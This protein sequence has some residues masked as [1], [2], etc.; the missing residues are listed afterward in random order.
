ML[1]R[2]AERGGCW[3]AA[4]A[5]AAILL[6]SIATG[7][8]PGLILERTISL[9][10]VHGRI[11]H[12]AIDVE[13]KRL[14]VAELGN[15]TVAAIDLEKEQVVRQ[16]DGLHEPQ[17][18]SYAP[19]T[20]LL[21]VASEGDGSVRRL[22]ADDLASAG[23]TDLK[24]DAD[25]I[26]A[27]GADRVVVGYG[28]G[29]L[30]VIEAATGRVMADI[31]MPAHPEGF[32]IDAA[33]ERLYVNL[34]ENHSIEAI[35]LRSGKQ[36]GRW[37]LWLAAGNFP[38]ALDAE[39]G[40]LFSAYRWPAVVVSIDTR[41]GDVLSRV[42]TCS[43]ADDL[44]YDAQRKRLYVSCGSGDIAILDAESRLLERARVPTRT[45]ART[46]LFVPALDRLFLAVPQSQGRAAEIRVYA[47]R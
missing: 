21:Y 1:R 25:N 37:G 34:P 4:L 43:D 46:S 6:S 18:L 2:R 30:A 26:R 11:D 41:T 19:A 8:E 7:A 36:V 29:G 17:G 28:D 23:V 20:G 14:F 39:G 42:S 5:G 33:G 3:L 35:D 9:G 44:F 13:H 24:N 22:K 40:R 45:G 38:M 47:P 15:G 32:Q 16:V 27:Y 12:L 10:A 31:K